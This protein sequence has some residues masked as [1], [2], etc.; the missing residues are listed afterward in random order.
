MSAQTL[1]V[2]LLGVGAVLRFERDA[3]SMAK[4][5]R[6]ATN[7]YPPPP[8]PPCPTN[9][10]KEIWYVPAP[11]AHGKQDHGAQNIGRNLH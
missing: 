7:K 10:G 8:P 5:L 1:E 2:S 3:G 9:S 11:P 6:Q 4:C